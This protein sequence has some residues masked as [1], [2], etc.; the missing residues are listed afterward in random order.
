M[1]RQQKEAAIS[2]F[3]EL[4]SN[5]EAAFLVR[6]KGL[7]VVALQEFRKGLRENNSVFKVTKTTLMRIVAKD[8][9]GADEFSQDFS[10]QVGIVFGKGDISALSKNIVNFAKQNEALQII[11]GFFE[12]KRLAKEDVVLLASLPSRDVLLAQVVGTMQAPITSFVRVLNLLIVQLLYV[13]KRI[14]EK[15]AQ[16]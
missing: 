4:F 13:L 1:N 16:S 5:S 8:I 3:K 11:S 14:E 2:D 6:Y 7:D 10:D 9:N 15:K 12:E